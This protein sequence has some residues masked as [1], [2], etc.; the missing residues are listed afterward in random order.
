[1]PPFSSPFPHD[2]EWSTGRGRAF[3]NI[4]DI[5]ATLS[6]EAGAAFVIVVQKEIQ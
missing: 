2:P 6:A 4:I 5:G 3:S 1:M